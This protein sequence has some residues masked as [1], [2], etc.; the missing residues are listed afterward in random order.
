MHGVWCL[1]RLDRWELLVVVP[2]TASPAPPKQNGVEQGGLGKDHSK[3][4]LRVWALNSGRCICLV[5]D[6]RPLSDHRRGGG[7]PPRVNAQEVGC[8]QQPW[9]TTVFFSLHF[10]S[11]GLAGQHRSQ[12]HS[13]LLPATCTRPTPPHCHQS[14]TGGNKDIT[15]GC[16]WL[17]L[18]ATNAVSGKSW[19]GW[20]RGL[21]DT[22]SH[23]P[24]RLALCP[25]E[26]QLLPER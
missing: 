3:I 26:P 12:S 9:E 23:P 5:R 24:P 10:V 15:G 16:R 11:K 4:F 8:A 14:T 2:A 6:L 18:E 17:L 7:G 25:Q 20:P 13:L 22:G 19:A 1:P 21:R